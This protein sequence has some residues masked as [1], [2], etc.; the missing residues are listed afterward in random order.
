[1]TKK[2]PRRYCSVCGKRCTQYQGMLQKP[3]PSTFN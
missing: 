3:T 2:I 1:M